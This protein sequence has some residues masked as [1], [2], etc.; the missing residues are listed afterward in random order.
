MTTVNQ[1][2]TN[3]GNKV[4]SIHS[5]SMVI[6]AIRLMSENNIGAVLVLKEEKLVGI[7]S[8]RDY[9]R[10]I[11]LKDKSSSN[12]LVSE[13]MTSNL[14]TV[15]L[16]TTVENCLMIMSENNIRHLPVVENDQLLGIVSIGDLVKNIIEDQRNTIINLE[17]YISGR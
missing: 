3:K 8:E 10:K 7:F 12:T 1:I 17:N 13:V 16:L 6:D 11:I 9:S 2:I 15:K 4:I 5:D 14:F